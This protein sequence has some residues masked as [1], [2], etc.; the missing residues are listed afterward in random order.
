MQPIK[1]LLISMFVVYGLNFVAIGFHQIDGELAIPNM[2][3][4]F[5]I[6]AISL[7]FLINEFR[8]V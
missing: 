3:L 1:L 4:G 8:Q 5:G 2:C 7:V 6:I